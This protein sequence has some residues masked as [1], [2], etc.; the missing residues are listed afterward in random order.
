[1]FIFSNLSIVK[2]LKDTTVQWL[3]FPSS[4]VKRYKRLL[5]GFHLHGRNNVMAILRVVA[6]SMDWSTNLYEHFIDMM[7]V[8]TGQI[9]NKVR[10]AFFRLGGLTFLHKMNKEGCYCSSILE[11]FAYIFFIEVNLRV[12]TGVSIYYTFIS[13]IPPPL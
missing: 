3:I 13:I 2:T 7:N 10:V 8:E 11:L 6:N 12:N 9:V 1:M 4:S 5:D